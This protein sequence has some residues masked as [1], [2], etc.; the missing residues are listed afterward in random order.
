M[1]YVYSLEQPSFHMYRVLEDGQIAWEQYA[2]GFMGEF[3]RTR[4]ISPQFAAV[5]DLSWDYSRTDEVIISD[6]PKSH[7]HRN[8][9]IDEIY[10]WRIFL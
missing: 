6:L 3:W 4:M 10:F 9:R 8:K 1:E 5:K 2:D 7:E